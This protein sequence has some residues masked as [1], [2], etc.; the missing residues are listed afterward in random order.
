MAT[1]GA[2]YADSR[3]DAV[4][5]GPALRLNASCN[6]CKLERLLVGRV[7]GTNGITTAGHFVPAKL[8]NH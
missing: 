3:G 6:I 8:R 5:N 4:S 2:A 7:E 1:W